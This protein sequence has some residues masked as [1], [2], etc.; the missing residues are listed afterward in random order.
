MPW[1]R[2]QTHVQTLWVAPH[3]DLDQNCLAAPRV[4]V[5]KV[6]TW[7]ASRVAIVWTY[8]NLVT[9]VWT[10]V[11]KLWTNFFKTFANLCPDFCDHILLVC[12]DF[13]DPLR[14]FRDPRR[15]FRE[16]RR[17]FFDSCTVFAD[18]MS[19]LS[20]HKLRAG[21][22]NLGLNPDATPPTRC[23][24]RPTARNFLDSNSRRDFPDQGRDGANKIL[25]LAT[26]PTEIDSAWLSLA[27]KPETTRPSR[28]NR[29]PRLVKEVRMARVSEGKWWCMTERY[30]K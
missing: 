4:C 28:P 20:R 25:F 11:V 29:R 19:R 3:P 12:L 18:L 24:S 5:W 16:P 27:T 6:W 9:K 1:S 10:W 13:R 23:L 15:I 26:F 14:N 30:T 17:N 21:L 8:Q 22:C 7:V 2:S